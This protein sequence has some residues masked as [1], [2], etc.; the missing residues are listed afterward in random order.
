MDSTPVVVVH[1]GAGD[2]RTGTDAGLAACVRAAEAGR[3]ALSSGTAI[4]A[5]IAA[6][7]VLEDDPAL[8]AGTG[9]VLTSDGT[10]ELDACVMDGATMRSG[11]VACLPPFHH[12]IDVAREVM[13]DGHYHLLV[14]DGAS[15]FAV[16]R[17]FTPAAPDSMILDER[18]AEILSPQPGTHAGNTVGAVALDGQGR[19]AAATSTG[20]IA[21]TRPGRVGDSPI[22]GGGT[23]AN[24]QGAC[25]CTGDGESF[26]RA[27][28]ALSV[29]EAAGADPQAAAAQALQTV[30][31]DFGGV[32]GLILVTNAGNVGV[33]RTMQLMPH[34]ISRAGEDATAG[35]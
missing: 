17:G 16:E 9:A 12:P 2:W 21:G 20:G 32:G 19:L 1:G 28:A 33:A 27:C 3:L 10:L 15:R 34:A 31:S 6:V 5:V 4:D 25:S 7:R 14:A 22:V 11:A 23:Y 29:V 30:Q 35:C 13:E 8:N 24:H 18:R 26:A